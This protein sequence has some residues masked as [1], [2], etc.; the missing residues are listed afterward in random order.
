MNKFIGITVIG[1]S[2]FTVNFAMATPSSP[3]KT[4]NLTP[5]STGQINFTGSVVQSTCDITVSNSDGTSNNNINLGVMKTDQDN[6]K[7]VNFY[8]KPDIQCA[9][10]FENLK[11]NIGWSGSSLNKLGLANTATGSTAAKNVYIKFDAHSNSRGEIPINSDEPVTYFGTRTK[12][13]LSY[14]FSANIE[15]ENKGEMPIAGDV[16][17]NVTYNVTYN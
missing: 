6:S 5:E 3:A 17:S 13:P 16:K 4:P 1:L 7:V 15:K 8:L 9:P 11:V 12:A 10:T 2:I 14:A